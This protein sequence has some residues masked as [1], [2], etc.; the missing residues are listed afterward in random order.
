[1]NMTKPRPVDCAS[2]ACPLKYKNFKSMQ[3]HWNKSEEKGGHAH[4]DGPMTLVQASAGRAQEAADMVA[5]APSPVPAP[6]ENEVQLLRARLKRSYDVSADLQQQLDTAKKQH[7]RDVTVL[8]IQM[9]VKSTSTEVEIN[10]LRLTIR[11]QAEKAE[12]AM[13]KLA[14]TKAGFAAVVNVVRAAAMQ[15]NQN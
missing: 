12:K 2:P 1:M 9:T 8:R 10:R 3:S 7:V 4:L 13:E 5:V 14:E 15:F 11:Q 6:A